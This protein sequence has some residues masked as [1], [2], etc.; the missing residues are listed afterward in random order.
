MAS[1]LFENLPRDTSSSQRKLAC[2]ILIDK[3]LHSTE[4]KSLSYLK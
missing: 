1:S 2:G 3:G 4:R